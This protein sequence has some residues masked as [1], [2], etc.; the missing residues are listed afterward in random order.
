ME[1]LINELI[2][3][4]GLSPEMAQKATSVVLE[5]VNNNLPDSL[6]GKGESLLSGNFDV[7]SLLG[8]N[9]EGGDGLIDKVKGMFS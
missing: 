7:K 4:A 3:K 5:Y 8:D 9:A 1:N 2:Q 6:K